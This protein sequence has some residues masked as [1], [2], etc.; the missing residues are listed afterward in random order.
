MRCPAP[1]RRTVPRPASIGSP[2]ERTTAVSGSLREVP[3]IADGAYSAVL[4]DNF[5]YHL[6]RP[7]GTVDKPCRP[8]CLRRLFREHAQPAP[9]TDDL[10]G[11]SPII[12]P[13]LFTRTTRTSGCSFLYPASTG[14][15]TGKNPGMQ[16]VLLRSCT[17]YHQGYADRY[18]LGSVPEVRRGSHLPSPLTGPP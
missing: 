17:R 14:A 10:H 4:R 6:D 2:V 5:L 7:A 9:D 3:V 18:I 11:L 1:P 15:A 12:V 16:T 13:S 8:D